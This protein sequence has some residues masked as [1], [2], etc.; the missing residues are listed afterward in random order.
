MVS[1]YPMSSCRKLWFLN[2]PQPNVDSLPPLQ[3][4]CG[5]VGVYYCSGGVHFIGVHFIGG[6]GP[7]V[8]WGK[9]LTTEVESLPRE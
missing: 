9:V 8:F 7:F 3:G 4:C 5:W 2:M 1:T 6:S